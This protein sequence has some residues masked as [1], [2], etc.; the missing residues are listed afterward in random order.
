MTLEGKGYIDVGRHDEFALANDF[1]LEAWVCIGDIR[2]QLAARVI[3]A[4]PGSMISYQW[5]YA[6][7][8]A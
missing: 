6:R 8:V 4:T 1:T 3:S 2:S 5:P 7:V